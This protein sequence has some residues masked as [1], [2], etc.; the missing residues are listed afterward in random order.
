MGHTKVRKG[1]RLERYLMSWWLS[2]MW[3]NSRVPLDFL[4]EVRGASFGP[5]RR[6]RHKNFKERGGPFMNKATSVVESLIP[7]SLT[8]ENLLISEFQVSLSLPFSLMSSN[9]RVT[10]MWH[11]VPV[12][13]VFFLQEDLDH[14]RHGSNF[15][16]IKIKIPCCS[17]L[18][19]FGGHVSGPKV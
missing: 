15:V 14:L 7:S 1:M 4:K 16:R 6:L 11:S 3:S 17:S 8:T 12:T 18:H 9:L 19:A 13:E 2:G 10:T 5:K